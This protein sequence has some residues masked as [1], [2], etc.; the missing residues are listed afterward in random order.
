MKNNF[1]IAA[2]FV[3]FSVFLFGCAQ[4]AAPEKNETDLPED[5]SKIPP[6][7]AAPIPTPQIAPEPVGAPTEQPP[8]AAQDRTLGKGNQTIKESEIPAYNE[9]QDKELEKLMEELG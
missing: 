9:S 1:I 7:T 2:I 8:T 3:V 5:L 6:P 4:Q